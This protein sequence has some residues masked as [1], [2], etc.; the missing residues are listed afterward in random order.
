MQGQTL[1]NKNN[2]FRC[3]IYTSEQGKK[4]GRVQKNFMEGAGSSDDR[5]REWNGRSEALTP[6]SVASRSK[7]SKSPP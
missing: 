2:M 4:E 7:L 1:Y 3:F 5:R 6:T